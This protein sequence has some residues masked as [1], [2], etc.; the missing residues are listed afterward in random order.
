MPKRLVLGSPSSGTAPKARSMM[1]GSLP[2]AGIRREAIVEQVG[3]ADA[4]GEP[5][6]ALVPAVGLGADPVLAAADGHQPLAGPDL[7]LHVQ[8]D[9]ACLLHGGAGERRRRARHRAVDRVEGEIGSA[10]CRE[11]GGQY[12]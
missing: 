6:V 5:V 4:A 9:L 1:R 7:V 2:P 10:S 3:D 11:R 8:A 12:V